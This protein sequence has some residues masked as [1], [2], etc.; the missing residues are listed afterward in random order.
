[1]GG[2][3]RIDE[4]RRRAEA[5]VQLPHR[6]GEHAIVG[7]LPENGLGADNRA[8]ERGAQQ[9]DRRNHNTQQEQK[10]DRHGGPKKQRQGCKRRIQPCA[11]DAGGNFQYRPWKFGAS[12]PSPFFESTTHAENSDVPASV[13]VAVALT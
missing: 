2:G 9:H 3:T 12:I 6:A 11:S 5:A 1:M 4:L 8:L 10:L 13:F 7:Q